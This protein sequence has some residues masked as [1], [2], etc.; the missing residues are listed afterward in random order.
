[1]GDAK[2]DLSSLV[3]LA[4][5]IGLHEH[6]GL[7]YETREQQLASALPFLRAGLERRERCLY[8]ADENGG[9]AVLNA[10]RE[11]GT[12]VDR[13]LRSGALV[14]IHP[15]ETFLGQGSFD[16]DSFLRFVSQSTQ[17]CVSTRMRYTA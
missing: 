3:E 15:R 2:P 1:V 17:R 12:D 11:G 7:I 16:P 14:L 6:R 8:V 5:G 10:L 9:T 13:F 4:A